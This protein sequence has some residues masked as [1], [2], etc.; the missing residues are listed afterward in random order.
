M[1]TFEL[2][3]FQLTTGYT[4]PNATLAYTTHGTLNDAKDNAVLFPNFLGGS[5]QALEIYIG[6]GRPLDPARH[7]VILPGQFG[8]GYSSSPSNTPPP[9]DRGAFPPINIADDVIAQHR[10][11]TEHFGISE[12]Q[13]VLGWSVGALQTFEWAVRFPQMV[14]RMASI[15]GAPQPSPWTLHWLYAVIEEPVTTDPAWN[16]G[17]Y[18]A[19]M[20]VQA[21]L[22]RQAHIMALTLPPVGYMNPETLGALGFASAQD[23]VR[24]FFEGFMVPQDPNNVIVQARKARA[25]DP[26]HGRSL[27]DALGGITAKTLIVAFNGDAMFP[28]QDGER[29]AGWI[30][31][32]RYEQKTTRSGHLTTFA[33]FPEDRDAVDSAIRDALA[34]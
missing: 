16:N 13:L 7:F 28:P 3:N 34:L 9:F 32:A 15:A 18:A 2:G 17:F 24:G 27:R 23:F 26:G 11:I 14:K 6:E 29:H 12:L 33:L 4:I 10:L 19:A 25:A 1:D 8:N 22:R 30:P 31:G 5:D 20:D 21:G